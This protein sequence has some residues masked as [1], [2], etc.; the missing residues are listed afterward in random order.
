MIHH[1]TDAPS[2][3]EL[4]AA[5]DAVAEAGENVKALKAAGATN[6]DDAVVAGVATLKELKAKLAAMEVAAG[7]APEPAPEKPKPAQQK[8]GGN[9]SSRSSSRRKAGSRSRRKH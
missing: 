7:I 1:R 9:N 6:K 5:S 4:K 3:E 2:A 8:K